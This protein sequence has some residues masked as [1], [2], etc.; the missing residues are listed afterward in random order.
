MGFVKSFDSSA[1]GALSAG[2][3]GAGLFGALYLNLMKYLNKSN[4][5]TI[6]IVAVAYIPYFFFF[7]VLVKQ[8]F[9]YKKLKKIEEDNKLRLEIEKSLQNI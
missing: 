4:T 8:L 2:T 9:V 3:G 7:A 1:V 6:I 5:I